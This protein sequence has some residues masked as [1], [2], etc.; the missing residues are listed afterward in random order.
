[1]SFKFP[2]YNNGHREYVGGSDAEMWYHIGKIQYHFLV[3]NGLKPNHTFL[4]LACGS[5][6]LGQYL[7]PM[8]DKGR[9]Y[10]L[11]AREDMVQEGLRNE[12]LYEVAEIKRPTFS[13]NHEF[14]FSFIHSFDY[15]IAQSL[16]THLSMEYIEVCFG[17]IV[18]VMND[19]SKF[20][21]TFKKGDSSK[22]PK[23]KMH[24]G[25]GWKYT[26][27]ELQTSADKFKLN[28]EYIGDW[29][30]PRKQEVVLCQK[31]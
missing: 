25:K 3:S 10:G 15:A 1:M 23:V 30:H 14:D 31:K 26:F 19:Q 29:K 12:L 18:K 11:D 24:P 17:N 2:D 21:F 4:D 6:R 22:N 8:L 16:F 20:Y 28:L 13:Y 5:L 7:I 9:Y 27:S